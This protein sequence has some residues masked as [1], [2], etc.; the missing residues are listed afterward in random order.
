[1]NALCV[2]GAECVWEDLAKVPDGWADLVVACND[3]G[4]KLERM[5]HWATLHPEHLERWQ[6]VRRE[7]G[8]SDDYGIWVP[9]FVRQDMTLD[10]E[11]NRLD[12]WVGSSGLYTVTVAKH[13]GATTVV[14]AG[15][16]M[17]KSGHDHDPAYLWYKA[18][19]FYDGWNNAVFEG[20][21]DGVSSLS[22]WTRELLGA[23]KF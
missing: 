22:G 23:P 15:I 5:D 16:P 7:N 20:Y 21:L 6:S 18:P 1:M 11:I 19:T 4:T 9:P 2:G 13:L 3:V 14:C 17:D 8:L 10:R 12:H